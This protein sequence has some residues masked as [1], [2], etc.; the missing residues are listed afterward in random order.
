MKSF[1]CLYIKGTYYFRSRSS[2]SDLYNEHIYEEIVDN[3]LKVRPLPPIPESN[4]TTAPVTGT[5]SIFTGATKSEILH[6][7]NDARLR[8]GGSGGGNESDSAISSSTEDHY[9]A[10]GVFIGSQLRKPHRI[11]AVSN[12]SDSS[13]SSADSVTDSSVLWRGSSMEKISGAGNICQLYNLE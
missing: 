6:Y 8:I 12:L 7:L 9:S 2:Q 3:R 10:D 1:Y 5:T 4:D 11:S 13:N